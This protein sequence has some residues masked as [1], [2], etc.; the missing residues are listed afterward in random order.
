M[1]KLKY[2]YSVV[3]R[4]TGKVVNIHSTR[5]DAREEKAA[6][7]SEGFNV[8]IIQSTFVHVYSKAIR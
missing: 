2:S 8:E 7:K 4:D 1:S 5:S 3:D 6:W